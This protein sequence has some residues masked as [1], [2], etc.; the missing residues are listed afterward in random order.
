MRAVLAVNRIPDYEKIVF[1]SHSMG[2][3]VTRA[4]LLKNR[5][6]AERTSFAYFFSTS[7]TGSQIASVVD[8]VFGNPQISKLKTLKPDEYLADLLRQWLAAQFHF[9]SYCAY[10]KRPT[11]GISLV[12]NMDSA[13]S[14]CTKA[15]DPIDTDHSDVVKPESE[16][17]TSYLVF[18]AAYSDAKIPGL[19]KKI[20]QAVSNKIASEIAEV[21]RFPNGLIPPRRQ[22]YWEA[23]LVNKLPHRIFVVLGAL[24]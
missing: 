18:K 9:P 8:F 21:C 4:Y 2:G 5:S 10:E 12:V 19:R 16:N 11:R 23:L 1:I 22:R 13:A 17:S 7:T 6:V 24:S 14:L 3:L 20:D 15:L